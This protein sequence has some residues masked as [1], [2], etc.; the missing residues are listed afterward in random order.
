LIYL[1][2]FIYHIGIQYFIHASKRNKS[3]L[4]RYLHYRLQHH[5]KKEHNMS[6]SLKL[7]DNVEDFAE[8]VAEISATNLRASQVSNKTNENRPTDYINSVY[9]DNLDL[10]SEEYAQNKP[11]KHIVLDNFFDE[12]YL[13]TILTEFPDL[14]RV[15][16]KDKISYANPRER[17][18]A[19]KGEANFG[20]STKALMHYLNSEP[21]LLWM[22]KLT[23]IEET[24]IPDPY[25]FGGGFHEIKPG[26]YLKVHADF[27]RHDK[28]GLDRRINMLVYLNEEWNDEFHGDLQLWTQDMKECVKSVMPKFN[29]IVIFNTDDFSYH[30]LPDA[31]A[32]PEGMSRKS[33]ALY[34]YSNGRPASEISDQD[35]TTLFK[36]RPGKDK[37]TAGEILSLFVP[38]IVSKVMYRL[39]GRQYE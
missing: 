7:D 28:L 4:A 17:K 21:F 9:F 1:D 8:N 38:P 31:V 34:Y 12:D 11:F 33:L 30:G 10:L 35:H 24:L 18:L 6:L 25:F 5:R 36:R 20:S 16:E 23:G 19:G 39:R 14:Q 22:Q 32:C 13:K 3:A 37:R 15:K 2:L 29:R 27:N 26:G